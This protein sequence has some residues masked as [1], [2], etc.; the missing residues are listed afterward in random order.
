MKSLF[1]NVVSFPSFPIL[2]K[3]LFSL[4][5]PLVWILDQLNSVLSPLILYDKVSFFSV[6]VLTVELYGCRKSQ[7]TDVVVERSFIEVAVT[8]YLL[9]FNVL[10]WWCA[11]SVQTVDVRLHVVLAKT[12][13]YP[14]SR[15][16]LVSNIYTIKFKDYC[17]FVYYS[18]IYRLLNY[19]RLIRSAYIE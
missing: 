15:H 11:H 10:Y 3:L 2:C 5:W 9:N 19:F 1:T 4:S 17:Q 14:A 7:Q 8:S 12:H 18:E 13:L 16:H 6:A